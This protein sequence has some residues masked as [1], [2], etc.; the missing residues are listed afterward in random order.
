MTVRAALVATIAPPVSAGHCA[1]VP[2]ARPV[3]G[4]GT[5]RGRVVVGVPARRGTVS[6]V[7][8]Q[9]RRRA[10]ITASGVAGGLLLAELSLTLL[11]ALEH[12]AVLF[13]VALF[14]SFTIEPV[15]ARLERRGWRR[16][17]AT[18]LSMVVLIVF[19]GGIVI[20]GGAVITAQGTALLDRVPELAASL[21]D[22]LAAW[23]LHV[24]LHAMAAPGGRLELL[25]GRL[26]SGMVRSGAQLIGQ[27]GNF[28]A[29]LFLVFYLSAD[30]HKLLRAACSLLP[31]A[32][33]AHVVRVWE[34]AIEKAGGYMYSRFVLAA[35]SSA[36]HSVAFVV[37]KVD[38]PIPLGLWV[39]VVSQLIPVIGSYL[40][41]ALPVVVALGVSPGQ[42][43]AVLAVLV[44]YQQIENLVLA[45]R[46]TRSAV[47]VH[48]L[49]GFLAVLGSV[50]VLG[51]VGALV[52]IPTLATVVAF[53]SSLLTRHETLAVLDDAAAANVRRAGRGAGVTPGSHDAPDPSPPG[54]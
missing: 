51:P 40:A 35:V 13:G 25:A 23:G 26:R 39:G 3:P 22:R 53:T 30:G 52:A 17:V 29:L 4:P 10:L 16:G 8:P 9:S 37:L 20:A 24:D 34:L 44:V 46:V 33:Q 15:V 6:G 43:L 42:A 7:D 19:L 2:D 14:V 28:L 11:H 27:A 50:A 36:V 38:Y 49:A 18:F 31:P 48:P 12:L 54:R 1:P 47:S 45:P 21:Q 41:G 32:R 5:G